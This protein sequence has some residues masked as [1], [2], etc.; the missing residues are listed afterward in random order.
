MIL[1]AGE[2]SHRCIVIRGKSLLEVNTS[3]AKMRLVT[4]A[5]EIISILA[6]DPD[7]EAK[8]CLEIEA[9]S[10]NGADDQIKGAVAE[11]ARTLGFTNTDWE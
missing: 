6:A 9:K 5:E 4:I 7:A 2:L 3:I 10:P 11:N 8:V 1:H